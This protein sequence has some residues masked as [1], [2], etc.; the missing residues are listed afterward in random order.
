M[1]EES[2]Q[3]C[4][5][6]MQKINYLRGIITTKEGEVKKW[7]HIEGV[8]RSNLQQGQADG[9]KKM[10]EKSMQR[11]EE[12]RKKFAALKFPDSDI[13]EIINRCKNCGRKIIPGAECECEGY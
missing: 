13:I 1:T 8:H 7:T 2:Y 6:A 12:C 10:I 9:A 3:Q 4:R 5:K 11:L